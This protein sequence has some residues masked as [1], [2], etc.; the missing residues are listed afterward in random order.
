MRLGLRRLFLSFATLACAVPLARAAEPPKVLTSIKP[1]HALAANIMDGVGEPTLLLRATAS[2]H[3]YNLRPSDARAIAQAEIIFWVGPAYESFMA[4]AARS[5]APKARVVTMSELAGVTLLPTREGGVWDDHDEGAA[6]GHSHGHSHGHGAE[7][8]DMHLWLDPENAKTIVQAMAA[9]LAERDPA[10]GQAY[11]A[12]AARLTGQ[13]DGLNAQL[14]AQLAPV[15]DKP[16]VVFHDAYQY[17][18][19]RYGL[20]AAGAIT[21]T[22]DRVPGPRRLAELRRTIQERRAA[23]VFSEPQFTSGLVTTVIEGTSARGGILDPLGAAAPEGKDGY[24]AMMHNL[25][26]G[27]TACLSPPS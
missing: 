14:S 9:T 21:V 20:T 7:E 13:L 26:N 23:C 24:L 16:F 5:R 15:A 2:P 3:T 17:F 6:A 10:N 1:L 25:A 8:M 27:L 12:N 4:K 19:R 11:R 22:P 18:E